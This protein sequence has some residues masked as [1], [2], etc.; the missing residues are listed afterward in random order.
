MSRFTVQAT[1]DDVP[2]LSDQDKRDLWN[3]FPVHEREARAKGVPMLGSGRIF[4]VD[5]GAITCPPVAVPPHWVQIVG[6][7][8][9]WDHPFAA[10]R[11]AWDRDADVVYVTHEYRQREA[12][13]PI[14]A[15]AIRAW[16]D[17]LPVAWPHDAHQHDKGSG[18]SLR[19][20]YQSHGLKMLHEQASHEAGG[21]SVE[22]GIT[23]MLE[24][25][26]TGRWQV[27][28]TCRS[29][30]EELRMYH[31]KDGKI[32]KL[33]DDLISASRYAL[34]MKRFAKKKPSAQPLK[35]DNRG[36]I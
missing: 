9:G 28:E 8:F 32:V 1:W 36:I 17:W 5:E 22:A 35:Y 29:W 19:D 14:H 6:I 12:T 30:L 11:M 33:R 34:M 10:A 16:G 4:P 20:Q 31:R 2:H 27:F 25:M 18:I 3:S 23:D 26:E 13:P 24:R 15:A 7:D 21:N